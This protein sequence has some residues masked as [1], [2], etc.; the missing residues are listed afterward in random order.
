MTMVGRAVA[1]GHRPDSCRQPWIPFS[2]LLAKAPLFRRR[3]PTMQTL[4]LPS[5]PAKVHTFVH[6]FNHSSSSTDCWNYY[7]FCLK[8]MEKYYY[9]RV[10][11]HVVEERKEKKLIGLCTARVK[12]PT[13]NS[14]HY[15]PGSPAR[16]R[17][18]ACRVA[19]ACVRCE[20][21][22]DRSHFQEQI[23]ACSAADMGMVAARASKTLPMW[24]VQCVRPSSDL[25]TTPVAATAP[26]SCRACHRIGKKSTRNQQGASLLLYF[27]TSDGSIDGNPR[28]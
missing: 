8:K 23:I 22:R 28:N 26:R 18:H 1:R 20:P 24:A 4:G 19:D 21:G 7:Y 6:P 5:L 2:S 3:G 14:T 11:K 25:T 10:L 12:W 16:R 9:Y 15:R 17:R 27:N 13:A